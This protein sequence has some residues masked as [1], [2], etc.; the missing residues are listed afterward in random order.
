V[1]AEFPQTDYVVARDRYLA[2]WDQAEAQFT[3]PYHPNVTM[4]WDSSP[5]TIQSDAYLPWNYPFTAVLADNTPDRFREALAL[6]KERLA[7]RAPKDRILTINAWN[8]WTES[9]YLEP[10]TQHG[11]G[12]LEA[13][14]DVF[15]R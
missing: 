3:L 10:D 13:I 1:L 8:E 5:R 15:G 9:S 4:G 2:Y 11:M 12:Y 7:A 14:R 6:T